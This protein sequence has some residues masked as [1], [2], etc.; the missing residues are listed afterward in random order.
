MIIGRSMC[1]VVIVVGIGRSCMEET[2]RF[3]IQKLKYMNS[4][5]IQEVYSKL[6][7]EH[8]KLPYSNVIWEERPFSSISFVVGWLFREASNQRKTISNCC[9]Q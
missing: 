5:F 4:N 2:K 7:G 8:E 6:T 1:L 9:E 3:F